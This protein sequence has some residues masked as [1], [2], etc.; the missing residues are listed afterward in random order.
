MLSPNNDAA[1]PANKF[2]W[3]AVATESALQFSTFAAG[4]TSLKPLLQTFQQRNAS[5]SPGYQNRTRCN[6]G[7]QAFDWYNVLD[8]SPGRSVQHRAS[9][10]ATRDCESEVLRRTVAAS[11][12]TYS[13][14]KVIVRKEQEGVCDDGD[15]LSTQ[16]N[17]R[18]A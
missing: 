13:S 18:V 1:L 5:H 12:T 2:L 14:T 6:R 16:E 7:D 15:S 9:I 8:R 11:F 10:N 4:M 17:T 3:A